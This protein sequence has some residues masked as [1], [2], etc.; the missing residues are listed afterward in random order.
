MNYKFGTPT[1][2]Q[3]VLWENAMSM[4]PSKK[5]PPSKPSNLQCDGKTYRHIVDDAERVDEGETFK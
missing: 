2:Q 5:S 4:P 3:Q 1:P